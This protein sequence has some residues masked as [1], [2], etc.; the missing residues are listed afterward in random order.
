LSAF[1]PVEVVS[2]HDAHQIVATERGASEPRSPS[3]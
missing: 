1:A 2:F 3:E